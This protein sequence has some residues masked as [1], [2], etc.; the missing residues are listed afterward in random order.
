MKT[1]YIDK[2]FQKKTVFSNS[3]LIKEQE[4]R[5]YISILIFL[6]EHPVTF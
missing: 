2:K 4:I 3:F 1:I 5:H 6:K